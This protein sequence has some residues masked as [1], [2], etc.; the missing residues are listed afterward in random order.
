MDLIAILQ[1]ENASKWNIDYD[2]EYH[3]LNINYLNIKLKIKRENQLYHDIYMFK[4]CWSRWFK[5]LD[6]YYKVYPPK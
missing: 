6:D 3:K 2:I 5:T 1:T 4:E